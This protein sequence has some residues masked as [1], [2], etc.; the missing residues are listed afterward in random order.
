MNTIQ[1]FSLPKPAPVF[2]AH[3][4]RNRLVAFTLIELLVVIAIIGILAGLIVG[5]S[6]LASRKM[7]ESRIRTELNQLVTA[8]ESYHA[9][10]GHYP[11][12]HVVSRNPVVV[13]PVL[14]PLFYELG[15]TLVDNTTKEFR[16]VEGGGFLNAAAVN[17]VFGVDGFVNASTDPKQVKRFVNFKAK[18]YDKPSNS[19]A[20]LLVVPVP[21]PLKL[22]PPAHTV[23]AVQF[24]PGMNPWRY[25][26]T[27]PTNN[28]TTFDL[29]AEYVD[30]QRT[31]IIC[32]WSKD[33]LETP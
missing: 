33:V 24:K 17:T 16:A 13:D 4:S 19:N 23:P 10:F 5:L 25:V 11:P 27:N 21:W 14:N 8:I 15:G 28:P 2:S 32:N 12:D 1:P 22:P 31:R 20:E 30:G 9:R 6:G 3:H 26:C 7:R 29:W 18:Q